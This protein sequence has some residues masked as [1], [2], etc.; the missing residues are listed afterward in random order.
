MADGG[1]ILDGEAEVD[2][3]DRERVRGVKILTQIVEGRELLEQA[4]MLNYI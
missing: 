1:W 3:K 2:G 4:I